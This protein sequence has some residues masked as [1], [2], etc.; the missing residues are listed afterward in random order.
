MTLRLRLP[1]LVLVSVLVAGPVRAHDGPHVAAPAPGEAP[2]FEPPAPGSYELPPIGR[3]GEH[4][5]L[6]DQGATTRLPGLATGQVAVVAF[7][8]ASCGHSCPAALAT[9]QRLDRDLAARD[10][11]AGRARLTTVSFDPERD[12]PARMRTLRESFAP[13]SDWRFLTASGP[14]MLEPVLADYGQRVTR[15]VD[16]EGADTG[17]LQH[18]LKVFLLD[19]RRRIRNVY[20]A[21][22][23]DPRLVLNDIETVLAD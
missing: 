8:Y 18:V 13:R 7:V 20:S 6:D 14:A 16:T 10:D 23:M 19:D 11:L 15:L 12:S 17:V 4:A 21:G 22:L 3:V 1:G 9:L 2:L 5:M